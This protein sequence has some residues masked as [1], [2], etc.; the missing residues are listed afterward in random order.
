MHML[1]TH[2]CTSLAK[3]HFWISAKTNHNIRWKKKP[4]TSLPYMMTQGIK[5][6]NFHL[7][8]RLILASSRFIN[9]RICK[10]EGINSL[11]KILDHRISTSITLRNTKG[12]RV[13][14]IPDWDVGVAGLLPGV[15]LHWTNQKWVLKR[16][17]IDWKVQKWR[18]MTIKRT[19]KG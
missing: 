9:N 11:N 8:A 5:W 19:K 18:N 10:L 14:R 15:S 17:T 13:Q 3:I 16:T 2:L 4:T 6:W 7:P 12:P 1:N